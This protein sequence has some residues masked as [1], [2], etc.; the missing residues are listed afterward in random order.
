LNI[1]TKV[2]YTRRCCGSDTP[3]PIPRPTPLTIPTASGSTQPFCHSTLCGQTD[4]WSRWKA[5]NI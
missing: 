5:R 2:A 3:S 4:R 1:K